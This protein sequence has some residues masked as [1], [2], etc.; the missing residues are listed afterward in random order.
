M[1]VVVRNGVQL[2]TIVPPAP[3]DWKHFCDLCRTPQ[4][5]LLAHQHVCPD[6]VAY[7][8]NRASLG[9]REYWLVSDHIGDRAIVRALG[10]P[11]RDRDGAWY[12]TWSNGA[13]MGPTVTTAKAPR[14]AGPLTLEWT[15]HVGLEVFSTEA[16]ALD[17][18]LRWSE[19]D[20][21]RIRKNMDW[22]R[23]RRPGSR[24]YRKAD[25][26]QVVHRTPE[27]DP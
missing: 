14:R 16:H 4:E 2:A 6:A 27:S 23:S 24:R 1:A 21:E 20:I 18:A 9:L 8:L 12:T 22:L 19:R 11:T 26:A 7:A 25:E 15:G 3:D 17:A 5:D 13:L 10:T